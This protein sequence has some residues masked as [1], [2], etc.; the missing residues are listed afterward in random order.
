MLGMFCSVPETWFQE[1]FDPKYCSG[2]S[3]K[4]D[5]AVEAVIHPMPLSV[6]EE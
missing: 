5:R 2:F 3:L 4:P 1:Y 6:F